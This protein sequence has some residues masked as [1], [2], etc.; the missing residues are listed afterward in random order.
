M[1]GKF[2]LI[3]LTQL[4]WRSNTFWGYTYFDHEVPPCAH[5][6]EITVTFFRRRVSPNFNL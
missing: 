5:D 1:P 6:V 4:L 2:E 3:A